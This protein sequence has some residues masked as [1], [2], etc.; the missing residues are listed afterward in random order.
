MPLKIAIVGSGPA[1]CYAAEQLARLAPEADIDVIDRLPTPYGLVRA[2]VAP[3][4][5]GTKSVERVLER[6]LTR[7]NVTFHGAVEI[8]RELGLDELRALYDAVILATGA[9]S[10]RRLDIP[11]EELPGVHGSGAFTRWIN[12]HPDDAD[13]AVDLDRIRSVVVIGHGN[14]A[15]DVA[16]VLAKS[17]DE[18][19]RSDLAPSSSRTPSRGRLSPRFTSWAAVARPKPAS[20]PWSST[21]WA[22]SP[23]RIQWCDPMISRRPP[24]RCW[25]SCTASRRSP[26]P[27]SRC[28]SRFISA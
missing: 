18:M 5:Q 1:G 13:R 26:I 9:P 6:A 12:G 10:D 28:G 8:G 4:H 2:G 25:R 22:A 27:A 21:R 15:I 7:P 24:A 20:P 23:A 19:A 16:R 3:D 11:G 17:R 14:V